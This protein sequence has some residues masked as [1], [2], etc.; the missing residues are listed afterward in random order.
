M[1]PLTPMD[2]AGKAKAVSLLEDVGFGSGWEDSDAIWGKSWEVGKE[3]L[4]KVFGQFL[5]V[6]FLLRTKDIFLGLQ[7]IRPQ[8]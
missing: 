8:V 7:L 5:C 6:F 3:T 2:E 4:D 1:L